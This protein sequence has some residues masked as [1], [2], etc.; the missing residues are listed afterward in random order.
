MQSDSCL[1]APQ[2]ERVIRIF[3][4]M[5]RK[6][7]GHSVNR[8]LPLLVTVLPF[9]I[10]C[11]GLPAPAQYDHS[12]L[13]EYFGKSPAEVEGAFG[14]PSSIAEDDKQSPPDNGT[15]E[16]KQQFNQA[17]EKMSYTY[18]TGDGDL[19]FRF[20]PSEEVYAIH[21]AG[22]SVSPPAQPAED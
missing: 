5:R 1:Y 11:D 10:G 8:I 7:A 20:N 19:V 15:A 6:K 22:K 2:N 17:T 4:T 9:L 18:S 21:Y 3:F 12:M 14:M 13:R 16:E